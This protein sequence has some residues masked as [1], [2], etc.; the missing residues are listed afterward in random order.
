MNIVSAAEWCE[1][2]Q[3]NKLLVFDI[4]E[5][6]TERDKALETEMENV[7]KHKGSLLLFIRPSKGWNSFARLLNTRGKEETDHNSF[8]AACVLRVAFFFVAP[9]FI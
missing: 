1:N 6:E 4:V 3:T 9:I 5:Q 2:V 8:T 7:C